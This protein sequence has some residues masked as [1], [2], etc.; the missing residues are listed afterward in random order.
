MTVS[1]G[2]PRALVDTN[3]VVYAYDLDDPRKHTIARE[4]IE[5]LSFPV[6]RRFRRECERWDR[7]TGAKG[8]IRRSSVVF[9]HFRDRF[10]AEPAFHLQKQ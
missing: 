7:L 1:T 5:R 10:D 9:S 6:T 2:S 8:R 4:L 3:V